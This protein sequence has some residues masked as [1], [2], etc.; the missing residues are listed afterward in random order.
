MH[1]CAI[2]THCASTCSYMSAIRAI[3]QLVVTSHMRANS[4]YGSTLSAVLQLI[5]HVRA[6]ENAYKLHFDDRIHG[7][8]QLLAKQGML[9]G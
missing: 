5:F 6:T 3:P 2:D 9:H 8:S 1:A 4:A 7:R